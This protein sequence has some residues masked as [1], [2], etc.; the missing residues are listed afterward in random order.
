MTLS[1]ERWLRV[2]QITGSFW[3]KSMGRLEGKV[4]VITAATSGMSLTTAKLFVNSVELVVDGET[5]R[6]QRC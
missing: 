5:T 2:S 6:I 4:A 1:I 3:G